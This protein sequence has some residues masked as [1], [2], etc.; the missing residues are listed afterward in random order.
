MTTP[1]FR[2]EEDWCATGNVT[3]Y[4]EDPVSVGLQSYISNAL[5]KTLPSLRLDERSIRFLETFVNHVLS[6]AIGHGQLIK[7]NRERSIIWALRT[8]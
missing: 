1:K 4:F 7:H 3:I 2:I 5:T 6:D 8:E